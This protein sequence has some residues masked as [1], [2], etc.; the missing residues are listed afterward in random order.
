M[1]APT[2]CTLDAGLLVRGADA[3]LTG[4]EGAAAR[5]GAVDIRVRGGRIVVMAAH[6]R[7]QAGERVL[8]A[9]GCVV[10]PGWVNTHHHL[11]QNLLKAVPAGINQPLAQWLASVPYPRLARFTPELVRVAA[12]LGMAE[13]LLAGAT[14]CA[15]HHYLYHG[16]GSKQGGDALFDVA[17]QLGMRFVLCRGGAIESARGHAGFSSTALSPETQREMLGDVER[18]CRLYHQPGKDAMRRVVLAPTTPTYSLPAPLLRELA[19]HARGLGLRLHSHLSETMGY[20]EWCRQHHD[21][22]PVEFVARHDWLGSDVWFAHLVHLQPEEIGL[23]A[24]SGTGIAHCPVSNARLGS[25]IAPLP[26]LAAAGVPIGLGVDGVASN[27]SG[28][29]LA[30]AHMAWLVHRAAQGAGATTVEQVV[31]W[32]SRGGARLLGLDAVGLLEPGMC[33]DLVV[34]ELDHPR[35]WGFHDAALAPVAAGEPTRVR[36]SVVHGRVVVDD[37]CIPGLDL[38][39]LRAQAAAGVRALL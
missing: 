19:A 31:H 34:Y 35:F 29:V 18:L 37:G 15:D 33:A 24:S 27:E 23:L 10:Q 14:T 5:A 8:D 4:H 12:Q 17:Q 30:E 28:S 9:R 22:L 16:G 7:A 2:T 38:Q 25:G 32:G 36:Y 39:R 3:V 11:F 1:S 13:L 6:L 21:C 26:Q 20:V